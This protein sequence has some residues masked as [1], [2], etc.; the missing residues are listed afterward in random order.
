MADSCST[1]SAVSIYISITVASIYVLVLLSVSIYSYNFLLE[2]DEKFQTSP[3]LKKCKSWFKDVYK[4]R[5]CYLPIITHLADQVTDIAVIVQFG[6]LALSTTPSDCGGLN[7]YY[8][9][10]LSIL[11]LLIYRV[12]SSVLI[13]LSTKMFSRLII[14]FLDME[15][16]RALY[17][18]YLCDKGEPCSPQRWITSLEAVFESSPQALIQTIFLI[19]TKSFSGS[20]V[21]VI[22]LCFSLLT[23]ISKIISDDRIISVVGARYI[24]F[25]KRFCSCSC[26]SWLYL[27]RYLWRIFDVS[28]RIFIASLIWLGLGGYYLFISLIIETVILLVIC[29]CSKRSEFL[30][31]VV[32]IIVSKSD[33]FSK[34]VSLFLIIYRC[35]FNF[36]FMSIITLFTYNYVSN[37]AIDDCWK[38]A[39]YEERQKFIVD[40]TATFIIFIYCWSGTLVMPFI[41]FFLY[42]KVFKGVQSNSRALEDMIKS[43]DW[44]GIIEMQAYKGDYGVYNPETNENLLMLSIQQKYGK[45]ATYLFSVNSVNPLDTANDG[46]NILQYFGVYI[47]PPE[48]AQFKMDTYGNLVVIEGLDDS[49][50]NILNGNIMDE[51]ED[52]MNAKKQL[53]L[54]KKHLS[55]LLTTIVQKYP[56]MVNDDI[57]PFL[58]ACYI[59]SVTATQLL[60][61][62]GSEDIYH[63]QRYAFYGD[64]PETYKWLHSQVVNKINLH[65]SPDQLLEYL[66]SNQQQKKPRMMEYLVH[67][68]DVDV[69]LEESTGYQYTNTEKI[70]IEDSEEETGEHIHEIEMI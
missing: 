8:L 41:S 29:V 19:K 54:N 23:I 58:F 34:K 40:D 67:L 47:S 6:E 33:E 10:G 14:Q 20:P 35:S 62:G 42:N 63:G 56:D 38:C 30:F 51:F 61:P 36:V 69:Q 53:K 24:S 65:L 13:Y 7:M 18:N 57:A 11:V 48:K 2:F 45:L 31:S 70:P 32:T 16:F 44:D 5:R 1:S 9:F 28:T 25:N 50:G 15:L 21:I 68:K 27:I 12:V 49:D 55:K 4:R 46:R 17:I 59:G 66:Q 64:Q 52:H 39:T 37:M 26:I 3:L 60:Y 43:K 22:S